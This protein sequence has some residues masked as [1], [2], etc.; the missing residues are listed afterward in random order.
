MDTTLL[1]AIIT[2]FVT[3]L[4]VGLS[5]VFS[6]RKDREDARRNLK[7]KYYEEFIKAMSEIVVPPSTS[8]NAYK[9]SPNANKHFSDISN[10]LMIVASP[11]VILALYDL[12]EII[13]K[14][15]QNREIQ[16]A[17]LTALI[18]AIREDI[19]DSNEGFDDSFRFILRTS[20]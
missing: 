2:G 5:Y 7:I 16:E 6:R 3:I 17:R 15:N 14:V 18:K 20:R 13:E 19:G 12:F 9:P 1:V 10:S 8:N 11:K 4:T